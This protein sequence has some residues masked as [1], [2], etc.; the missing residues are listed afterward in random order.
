L[1][2]R[3]FLIVGNLISIVGGIICA[4]AQ[5]V[6][7]VIVGMAFAGMGTTG[8]HFAIAGISELFP[9]KDR[10]LAQGK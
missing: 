9:H 2:R 4:T 10:G 7:V 5:S 8:Q 3:W 6:N 1:G